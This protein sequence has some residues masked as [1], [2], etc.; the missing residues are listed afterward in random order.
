[1]SKKRKTRQ[2]KKIL[3]L[4][5]ELART[6]KKKALASKSEKTL[7][8]PRVS[9]KVKAQSRKP[10]KK[11]ELRYQPEYDE[12]LIKKDLLKTLVLS[13]FLLAL[14]SLFYLYPDS[15]LSLL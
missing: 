15:L 3:K 10:L 6:R 9:E 8:K 12:G 2:Q 1:M 11:P 5:R 7:L 4:K 13:F 14:I